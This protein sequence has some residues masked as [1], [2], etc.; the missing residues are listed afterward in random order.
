M[1]DPERVAGQELQGIL[2]ISHQR[3]A[4]LQ[5]GVPVSIGAGKFRL[6]E[7]LQVYVAYVDGGHATTDTGDRKR[8]VLDEQHRKLKI[9]NDARERTLIPL[10]E[11]EQVADEAII[12][13]RSNLEGVAGRLSSEL[14]GISDEHRRILQSCSDRLARIGAAV[15][16]HGV[17]SPAFTGR[18]RQTSGQTPHGC[19]QR[20]RSSPARSVASVR[21]R[22]S[23]AAT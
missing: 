9:A 10:A 5:S 16:A 15:D 4:R 2:G 3:V 22:T 19:C 18:G 17:R 21:R 8:Q 13:F 6:A 23:L 12:T 7:A 1:I 20:A 11:A 14:A